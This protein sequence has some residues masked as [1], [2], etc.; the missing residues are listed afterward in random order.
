M[1]KYYIHTILFKM[2]DK[3]NVLIQL[4]YIPSTII[5]TVNKSQNDHCKPLYA[6][7]P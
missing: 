4:K 3:K 2:I 5:Q 6:T 1:N 7:P